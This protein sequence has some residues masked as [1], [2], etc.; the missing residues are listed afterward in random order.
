MPTAG[1]RFA[2]RYPKLKAVVGLPW[3]TLRWVCWR[4]MRGRVDTSLRK[5]PAQ[6]QR[7]LT[8]TPSS[9]MDMKDPGTVVAKSAFFQRLPVEIRRRILIEAF[10][11]RT[12]HMDLIYDHEPRTPRRCRC[13]APDEASPWKG[14]RHGGFS[15]VDVQY[16]QPKRWMWRSSVCHR[17]P[18]EPNDTAYLPQPPEDLCRFGGEDG[19][20]CGLWPGHAPG[21]CGI[22]AMGWLLT[23]RQAY[24][25]GIEV[26]YATN[27]IHCASQELLLRLDK[28]LLPQRRWSM[29]S[30]ELI[31]EFAEPRLQDTILDHANYTY[32]L[33]TVPTVLPRVR[34]FYLSVQ[35][36]KYFPEHVGIPDPGEEEF[37]T[38]ETL[39]ME[40][41]D[42]LVRRLGPHV[43]ECAVAIPSTLYGP[44]RRRAVA[45]GGVVE[46]ACYE[47]IERLWR[48]LRGSPH[49]D[50]YWLRHGHKNIRVP[51]VDELSGITMEDLVLYSKELW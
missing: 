6:R 31:W 3:V 1:S 30:V 2:A 22:G 35:W 24:V 46:Y 13:P 38:D 25:E 10:G 9:T 4:I 15:R 36:P 23:C 17:N 34:S 49:R 12:V 42:H 16:W 8:P 18:P 40:P 37:Q 7:P 11:G 50:G 41:L 19:E 51:D 28:F 5:L 33:R 27:T 43:R 39:I 20:V 14:Y 48:P 26:L 32:F 21:K 45:A 29:A 44:R 47:G